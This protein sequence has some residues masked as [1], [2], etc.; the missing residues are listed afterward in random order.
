MEVQIGGKSG[1]GVPRMRPSGHVGALGGLLG[2]LRRVLVEAWGGPGG[3]KSLTW[4]VGGA[5]A[6]IW[7]P[8]PRA[9]L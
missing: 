5:L 4:V 2:A 9:V 1:P 3:G 7:V 8:M 6:A